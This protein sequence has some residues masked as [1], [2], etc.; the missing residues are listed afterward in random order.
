MAPSKIRQ[1][2][3]HDTSRSDTPMTDVNDHHTDAEPAE[4][5]DE[6]TMV[7][8]P[9]YYITLFLLRLAFYETD[10]WLDDFANHFNTRMCTKPPI[11]VYVTT[12]DC[13]GSGPFPE[14]LHANTN[15]QG[16]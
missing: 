14:V 12:E 3:T 10:R 9:P 2:V 4:N 6:S 5:G 13:G 16:F 7:C 8:L 15:R 11:T 1:S